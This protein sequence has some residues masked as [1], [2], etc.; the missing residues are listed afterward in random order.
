MEFIRQSEFRDD[1]WKA[2]GLYDFIYSLEDLDKKEQMAKSMLTYRVK[3]FLEDHQLKDEGIMGKRGTDYPFHKFYA[4]FMDILDLY[5]A[6]TF[7][8]ATYA[9]HAIVKER[10]EKI[11]RVFETKDSDIVKDIQDNVKNNALGLDGKYLL[12]YPKESIKEL[13]NIETR[14]R[15]R[16]SD[17]IIEQQGFIDTVKIPYFKALTMIWPF[18]QKL[19]NS[20]D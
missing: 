5:G 17:G 9:S 10:E 13:F 19:R 6:P 1:I 7:Y 11:L 2:A 12:T 20:V 8:Y 16:K 14:T 18:H 3:S 15:L 4:K